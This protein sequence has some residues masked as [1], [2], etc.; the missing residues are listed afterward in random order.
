[1]SPEFL[2]EVAHLRPRTN[3]FGAVTRIRNCLAQ[4]VHRFFHENGFNWISTPIITTSDAEGAAVPRVHPGH[5]EPAARR[6]GRDR[7]QPRLL[8]QGNL[9]DRVWPAERR[10]L[11]PALSSV[12]TF[13]PTFRAENSHTT[14]HPA[15]FWMIEP[16]IAFADLAED[17][18]PG[19]RVPEVPVPRGAER[20]QRRPGLHRRARGQ[21][22]D[23]QAG[24]FHQRTVRAHRLHRCGQPAA[25]VRQEVR[26]P[27]GMGPGPADR[28][29]ALADRGTRR[30]PGGGDQLPGAHQGLLHAPERRR[31]DRCRDGRAGPGH[32]RDH[33]RQ[34]ARRAPDVLDARMAQFGRIASTTAGTAISAAM[35]RCRTPASAGLRAPG[36]LRLRA[37]QHP[38][39]DPYPRAPG[40][41]DF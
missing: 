19:R 37:V 33:R 28:A 8:R 21:E 32:R 26:L 31:Q 41:A 14:R 36:G 10:G 39:C 15:E 11:L 6:E 24:R 40:S 27:G 2:R 1:M 22:R 17:A 20:A 13:G 12:Y 4:A 38:R 25:E 5:G 3:L 23:H 29:R 18:R 7:F 30:P 34:P 35:V 16:E 9:P